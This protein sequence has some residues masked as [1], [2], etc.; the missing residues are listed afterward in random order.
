MKGGG[1]QLK[2]SKFDQIIRNCKIINGSGT[3]WFISD[4]AINSNKIAAIGSL[5]HCLAHFEYD[6]QGSYLTPGI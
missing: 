6:A 1:F 2:M 4:L 3:P 5:K